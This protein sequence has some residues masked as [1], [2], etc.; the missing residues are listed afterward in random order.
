MTYV[1]MNP[2]QRAEQVMKEQKGHINTFLDVSY[3]II[4]ENKNLTGLSERIAHQISDVNQRTEIGVESANETTN[5]IQN[6]LA[7]SSETK[8][9]MEH[10][11]ELSQSILDI[12]KILE[13]V[14]SQTNL[15]ALNASIEAARAGDAGRGF[16]VVANEVKKLSEQSTKA[17]KN[18]KTAASEIISEIHSAVKGAED[19]YRQA[20]LGLE[21]TNETKE[22]L[23]TIGEEI[24]SINNL[25]D[26]LLQSSRNVS[27]LSQQADKIS[28]PIADNRA[29]IAEGLAYA[30]EQKV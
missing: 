24:S 23:M 22:M 5:Q 17:S 13:K 6:I 14:S 4:E 16:N 19:S 3:K 28:K 9:T 26:N 1:T 27:S 29:I 18:V 7:S 12:V 8:N 10:L 2:I 20:Q 25:K 15:L 11:S 21:R 30:V